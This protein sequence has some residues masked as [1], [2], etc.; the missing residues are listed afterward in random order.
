[1]YVGVKIFGFVGLIALPVT[2]VVIKYLYDNDK[3]H[4]FK[5]EESL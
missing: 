1:M 3:I 4:I 5:Q 2:I